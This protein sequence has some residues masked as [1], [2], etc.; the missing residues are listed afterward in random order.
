MT[1]QE[2][3]RHDKAADAVHEGLPVEAELVR[4]A[5][6]GKRI[7]VI[8]VVSVGAAALLLLGLWAVSN[9]DFAAQNKNATGQPADVQAFDGDAERPPTA[10]APT[11]ATGGAAPVPTG[12]APNVNAPTVPSNTVEQPEA[13]SQ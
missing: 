6:P 11:N 13:G 3:D 9:G 5:R 12:Q 2:P 8:L 4:G 7:M 1:P 10:D